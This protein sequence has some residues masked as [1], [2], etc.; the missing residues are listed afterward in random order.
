MQRFIGLSTCL[1]AGILGYYTLSLGFSAKRVPTL[2]DLHHVQLKTAKYQIYQGIN[3]VLEN[4]PS[5]LVR[6]D[7]LLTAGFVISRQNFDTLGNCGISHEFA[8]SAASS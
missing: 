8:A 3:Y 1:P 5:S 2:V 4:T 6:L 7:R